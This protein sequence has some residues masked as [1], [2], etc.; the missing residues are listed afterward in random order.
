VILSNI[1]LLGWLHAAACLIALV[2]GAYMLIARKGTARHRRL[3]WWY[4]GAMLVANLAIMGVYRFD[5]RLGNPP[6]AMSGF[7][8]AFHWMAVITLAATALGIFAATRQKRAVWAHVHAQ[9]MLFSYY[10]LASGLINQLFVRV[11]AVRELAM[12][13]SPHAP[14][15]FAG[16]LARLCQTGWMMLWLALAVWFVI[17]VM[18]DR[19]PRPVTLGHPLQY[20]GGLMTA[21]TGAGIAIGALAGAPGY[22]L[23]AGLVIGVILARRAAGLVRPRWGRPSTAQLRV[24]V[25]TIGVEVAVFSVLGASGFFRHA[26]PLEMWQATATIVGLSLLAMRWSHGPLMPVLGLAALAWLGLCLE[27]HAPLMLMA[28]GDGLIKLG[29]GLTMARPL[30]KLPASAPLEAGLTG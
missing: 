9:A 20:S 3:G 21:V 30:V 10:L 29:F 7:F 5:L 23:I 2:A 17:K 6:K 1:V 15:P 28:V 26:A 16:M 12:R 22:G 27:V 24:L 13:I 8:G 4:A 19:A 14:A 18:R 25:L 11:V